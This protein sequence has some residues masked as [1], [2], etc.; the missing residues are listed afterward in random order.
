VEEGDYG[1]IEASHLPGEA[2]GNSINPVSWSSSGNSAPSPPECEAGEYQPLIHSVRFESAL[3][4][5]WR[6]LHIFLS[7]G[8]CEVEAGGV[9]WHP[10]SVTTELLS[11]LSV[12]ANYAYHSSTVHEGLHCAF[13]CCANWNISWTS[14]T[15]VAHRKKNGRSFRSNLLFSVF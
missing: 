14:F 3:R 15:A 5:L 4:V 11:L 10:L 13:A 12:L 6:N 8:R 7:R 1:P 2:E 9:R